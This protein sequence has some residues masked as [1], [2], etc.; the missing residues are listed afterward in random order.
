MATPITEV[1]GWGMANFNCVWAM[2][3]ARL[4]LE[5]ESEIEGGEC[6]EI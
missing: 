2:M 5:V 4:P 1:N 6:G 3:V